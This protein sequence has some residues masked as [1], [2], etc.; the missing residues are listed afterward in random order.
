[1]TAA[2]IHHLAGARTRALHRAAV[3]YVD[4]T[5]PAPVAG[6]GTAHPSTRPPS[7]PSAGPTPPRPPP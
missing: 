4:H 3:L 5:V 6:R 1:M 7:P 2:D